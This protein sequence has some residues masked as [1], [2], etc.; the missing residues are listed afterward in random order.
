MRLDRQC[1]RRLLSHAFKRLELFDQLYDGDY[2][3]N[4]LV[5]LAGAGHQHQHGVYSVSSLV[6]LEQ[7]FVVKL[8]SEELCKPLERIQASVEVLEDYFLAVL[9]LN[10]F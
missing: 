1:K 4:G 8:N 3:L 6:L 2:H 5:Q 7:A 10:F 9:G